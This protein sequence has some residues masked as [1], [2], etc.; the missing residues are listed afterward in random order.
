MLWRMRNFVSQNL[1][2]QLFNTMI[3]PLFS[4]CNFVYD[5][6]TK[7][8]ARDI[9]ILHNNALRAVIKVDC[10]YSATTLHQELEVE[11]QD[12]NRKIACCAEVFKLLN[13]EGPP[14]LTEKFKLEESNRVLR[15]NSQMQLE[16]SRTHTHLGDRDFVIRSMKYWK[17]TLLEIRSCKTVRNLKK[18]LKDRHIFEHIH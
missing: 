6:C 8:S 12:V 1:A 10:R 18:W 4:Y 7:T 9:E 11:W 14:S 3:N 13:D 2:K 16:I 5:G 17:E 15:S